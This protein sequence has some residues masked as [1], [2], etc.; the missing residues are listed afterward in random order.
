MKRKRDKHIKGSI[1]LLFIIKYVIFTFLLIVFGVSIFYFAQNNMRGIINEPL[2]QK[3]ISS[4]N[5]SL[6]FDD[7]QSIPVEKFLGRGS[8]IQVLNERNEIIYSSK[9]GIAPSFY[10]QGELDCIPAY[11]EYRYSELTNVTLGG[12]QNGDTQKILMIHHNNDNKSDCYLLNSKNQILNGNTIN[13]KTHFTNTELGYFTG[14]YPGN[15]WIQKYIFRN[16]AGEDR[17]MLMCLPVLSD[18]EY[19]S[20]YFEV[21]G[22]V[23][24]FIFFYLIL[25]VFFVLILDYQ[26]KKPIRILNNALLNFAEGKREGKIDYSGPAEFVKI[27]NSFNIMSERLSES[28]RENKRLTNE[29]NKM[30]AD[31]SHDLKTPATVI[32]GYA[33]ALSDGLIPTENQKQYLEII[34]RKS[35]FIGELTNKFYE[36]SKL[37]HPDFCLTFKKEDI[38]ELC[39]EYLANRFEELQL[40]GYPLE[41][42]I[43]DK[44]LYINADKKQLQRVFDNLLSNTVSHTNPGTNICFEIKEIADFISIVYSDNGGGI[45]KDISQH[46]FEPFIV[47][48]FARNKNGSG[49]GL[50]IAQKI[51]LAHNGTIYLSEEAEPGIAMFIIEIPKIS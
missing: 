1:F 8:I 33:K 5:R 27:C 42:K 12:A 14:T 37:E 25:I 30:L 6:L 38:C 10:T 39:R 28:E 43:P 23:A 46:I 3:M 2:Y 35:F 16:K 15:I 41:V 34:Y 7:Y 11:N 22:Y 13:G 17:T 26:F 45:A 47:D 4:Y 32:Q 18:Y 50:S 29:K 21:I 20:V 24:A 19:R 36:F 51:V 44:N 40:S 48:D 49:L 31:I 9:G